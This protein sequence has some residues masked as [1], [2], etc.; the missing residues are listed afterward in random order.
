MIVFCALLCEGK[1]FLSILM[2]IVMCLHSS[3]QE[4]D[5]FEHTIGTCDAFIF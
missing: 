1:I 2:A 4:E 5:I 3:M